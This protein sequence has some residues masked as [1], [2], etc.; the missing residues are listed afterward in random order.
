[1]KLKAELRKCLL[2][3]VVDLS[4]FYETE[5]FLEKDL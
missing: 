1:M 3:R 5:M 4:S 2:Y